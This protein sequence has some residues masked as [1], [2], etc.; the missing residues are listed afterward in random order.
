M[1]MALTR[2][3]TERVETP[4]SWRKTPGAFYWVRSRAFSPYPASIVGSGPRDGPA[5]GRSALAPIASVAALFG[6]SKAEMGRDRY[7]LLALPYFAGELA[8]ARPHGCRRPNLPP[9]AVLTACQ[10][11]NSAD[12]SAGSAGASNC[13]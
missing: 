4:C 5:R 11:N 2:S 7:A 12:H 13:Q 10:V 9:R 6:T 3:S 1:P 8:F